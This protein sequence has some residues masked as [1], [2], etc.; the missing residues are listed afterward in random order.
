MEFISPGRAGG[1]QKWTSDSEL[2]VPAA[3]AEDQQRF[4]TLKEDKAVGD[5]EEHPLRRSRARIQLASSSIPAVPSYTERDMEDWI[6]NSSSEDIL[7]WTCARQM[8]EKEETETTGETEEEYEQL[9]LP[10]S[11]TSTPLERCIDADEQAEEDGEEEEGGGADLMD[12]EFTRDYYRLVKF[13]SSRSLAAS[14][15]FDHLSPATGEPCAAGSSTSGESSSTQPPPPDR[16]EALRTVL[17]FIAEQQRYCALRQA[18]D[19]EAPPELPHPNLLAAADQGSD[20]G[21]GAPAAGSCS[22]VQ[23]RHLM[24]LDED[25][26]SGRDADEDDDEEED[27]GLSTAWMPVASNTEARA[28]MMDKFLASG[29]STTSDE[30]EEEEGITGPEEPERF[31]SFQKG[32]LN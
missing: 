32:K 2:Q 26:S 9:F 18:E 31:L 11:G 5:S 25:D 28:A 6:L 16:Q 10:S 21:S 3:D 12:T 27:C 17:D 8:E 19:E 7:S 24:Q 30:E 22:L 29:C 20:P 4:R 1:L 23:L 14:D 15:K 13:E